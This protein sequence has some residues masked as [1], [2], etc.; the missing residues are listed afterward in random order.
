M[1]QLDASRFALGLVYKQIKKDRE[2]IIIV[3][4]LWQFIIAKWNYNVYNQELLAIVEAF[5]H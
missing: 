4:Y 1:I 3:F 5:K 2:Q